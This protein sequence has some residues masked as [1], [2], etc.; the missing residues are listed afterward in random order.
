LIE[1][2]FIILIFSTIN[3][4][5]LLY[6][7]INVS[8]S[9]LLISTYHSLNPYS[10]QSI[11]ISTHFLSSNHSI[12]SIHKALV[13]YLNYLMILA[14]FSNLIYLHLILSSNTL[15]ILFVIS[16]VLNFISLYYIYILIIYAT[17]FITIA[18]FYIDAIIFSTL[19][20]LIT[21]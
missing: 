17:T 18:I 9:I 11:F 21:L 7:I 10:F 3:L 19:I 5:S 20:S 12:T 16:S 13:A 4:S 8:I 1:S 6:S 2:I 14:L 15:S